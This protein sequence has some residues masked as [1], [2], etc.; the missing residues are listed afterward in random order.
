MQMSDKSMSGLK[1]RNKFLKIMVISCQQHYYHL[2]KQFTR[3]SVNSLL[4]ILRKFYIG[5]RSCRLLT[6]ERKPQVKTHHSLFHQLSQARDSQI[7]IDL[8]S[9]LRTFIL[10]PQKAAKEAPFWFSQTLPGFLP[11]TLRMNRVE[12][13]K[14]SKQCK[15]FTIGCFQVSALCK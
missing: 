8:A 9:A 7:T 3:Y 15:Y 5:Q 2:V 10:H 11:P 13:P 1:C 4:H 12:H 14:L 6:K